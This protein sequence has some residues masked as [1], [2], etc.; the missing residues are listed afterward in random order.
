MGAFLAGGLLAA[1]PASANVG[2]KLSV[3]H[4]EVELT[5]AGQSL[6][7]YAHD[8]LREYVGDDGKVYAITWKTPAPP[9][10]ESLL[11][12]YLAEYQAALQKPHP[13]SHGFV[14]VKTPHVTVVKTVHARL[15]AGS[16]HLPAH[17]PKGTT[18]HDLP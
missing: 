9:S 14:L 10:V 6:R 11:G 18:I 17:M 1:R 3:A 16:I 8:G 4:T 2:D 15:A 13:S 5:S 7:Y 12:P